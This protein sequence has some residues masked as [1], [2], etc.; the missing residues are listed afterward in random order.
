[1]LSE[2]HSVLL[3]TSGN[4]IGGGFFLLVELFRHGSLVLASTAI[5]LPTRPPMPETL[6]AWTSFNL[7]LSLSDNKYFDEVHLYRSFEKW[8][9]SSVAI[10]S[11]TKKG[12]R[13]LYF[14]SPPFFTYI[15]HI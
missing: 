4:A 5:E 12:I 11:W 9:F 14:T 1:M 15:D 3:S 7:P 6:G 2:Q 10:T 8:R 13:F